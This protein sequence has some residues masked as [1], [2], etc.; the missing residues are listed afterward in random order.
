MAN[1]GEELEQ[2]AKNFRQ[3]LS[4][5]IKPDI[6]AMVVLGQGTEVGLN[7]NLSKAGAARVL[8]AL[9]DR[10]EKGDG[11]LVVPPGLVS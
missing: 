4:A 9:A 6:W 5:G 1:L 11:R 3:Q 10:L 8:R 2:A 7:T